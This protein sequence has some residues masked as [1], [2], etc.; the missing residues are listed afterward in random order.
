MSDDLELASGHKL[1]FIQQKTAK[2]RGLGFVIG[3]RLQPFVCIC[4]ATIAFGMGV[5]CPDVRQ[6]IHVGAP[7]DMECYVQETG[8]AGRDG[9]PALALLLRSSK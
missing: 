4:I 8:R 9:L 6:V 7:S 2:Y 5:D 1:V 3:P